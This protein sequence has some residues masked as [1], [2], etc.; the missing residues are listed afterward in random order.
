MSPDEALD[1]IAGREILGMRFGL[2]RMT[3]LLAALGNPERAAPALHVVGTNGKSS[4]TRL[5]A[6]ALGSG[7]ARVG[8]YLSPHVTGWTERIQVDGEPLDDHAF[9]RAVGAA[10]EAAGGLALAEGDEVTQFEALTAAAF[11]TF[12]ETG[13]AACVVEAGLGGRFDATNVLQP[14]AA[15][16][17]TTIALDHTD[18]LG[19]TEEAIAAEKLA[20]CADGSDRLVVGRLSGPARIAV[21]AECARRGLRP[22]RYGLTVTARETSEGVEVTTPSAVYRDLPLQLAGS[23]QRDNLAVAMAG[24]EMLRAE[25]FDL[26]ALAAAV[27]GVRMPGRLEVVDTVPPIVLDGA[28]NPA[29]IEALVAALPEVLAGRRPAVAVVS[30][31]DDKDAGA[32]LNALAPVVDRILVTRSGHARAASAEDLAALAEGLGIPARAV[33]GPVDALRAARLETGPDGVVL[34]TGSLYLLVDLRRYALGEGPPHPPAIVAP[35]R[36]GTDPIEA[37]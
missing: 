18:F 8:A 29:G 12:R 3:A 37:N 14:R 19:D 36:K 28:H 24:A 21:E 20:V 25:P 13:A 11:W 17:L 4:T 23:F 10:R 32:M 15:V 7:G 6:A 5:A 26:P 27:A 33:P 34:V 35:A 31:L 1:W 22:L 2:E 16:A 30:V 9:A